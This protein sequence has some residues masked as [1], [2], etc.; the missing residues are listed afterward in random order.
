MKWLVPSTLIIVATAF[1]SPSHAQNWPQFR[2]AD[3][4]GVLDSEKLPT[5]WSATEHVAWKAEIPGRGWSSPVIWGNQVFVTSVVS[6]G[7]TEE[8]KKGLYFGGDRKDAPDSIH[9]WKV[10]ALDLATGKL[11]WERQVHEGKPDTPRHLKNSYA[12]ETPVVDGDRLYTYFGG[13]GIFCF[14]HAGNAVWE[15]PIA[16]QK[17]A[18][19]WGTAASPIVD[20]DRLYIIN[21][22]EEASYLLALDKK[23]GNEIW[24]VAREE[25]SNWSTPYIW[26]NSQHTELV[27]PGTDA[28]R[29]YDLDGKLLWSFKGM[30]S[31]TI[32]T[33]YADGDL[34]Y[35]SSGYVGDKDHRPIYA[36]RP[37]ASGDIS[38]ADGQTSNDWIAWSRILDAP[39]NPTT[40]VYR[41][42]LYVLYDRGTMSCYN[43]KDGSAI[44]EKQELPKG[45]GYTA[46]P[47]ASN[48]YI[49]CLNEDGVTHVIKAGD[50]FEIAHTNSLDAN[51]MG[52]A[53]P[54]L[55]PDRILLRTSSRLYA[56]G[57]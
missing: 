21:D 29:S 25:G 32:A 13:V 17:M 35:I 50:T 24:R 9:Q 44:Y 30:S 43:A 16:P 6:L 51:D 2:G 46:S 39:Y 10:Y 45:A 20:G 42:R 33:P 22:N 3:S 14:D 31:I 8:P 41:D 19:G 57:G 7:P 12:S 38:L 48:G 23:T 1:T 11:N 34:L 5:T 15:K 26:K 27:T 56:I 54:A 18:Y 28:V 37:G 52:M 49:Y 4:R 40:L 47:W 53:T 36:V 55:T